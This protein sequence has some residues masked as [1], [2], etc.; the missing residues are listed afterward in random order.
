MDIKDRIDRRRVTQQDD[1]LVVD[2]DVPDD[3]AV[4]GPRGTGKTAVTEALLTQLDRH[5][6]GGGTAIRTTTRSDDH[7]EIRFVTVDC[8][9]AT[10]A[11]KFYRSFLNALTAEQVPARGIG[12][13]ALRSRLQ[14]TLADANARAIVAVDHLDDQGTPAP[15]DVRSYLDPIEDSVAVL[16]I[17]RAAPDWTTETIS[18]D[19]YTERSLLAIISERASRGFGSDVLDHDQARTIAAWANG[20]AHDALAALTAAAGY[21]ERADAD[22]I[23]ESHVVDAIDHVP[24]NGVHVGRIL[25]LPDNRQ[26]VLRAL[27]EVP[28]VPISELAE[29]VAGRCSLS[30]GTVERFC[31][32]LT[33]L[34]ILE[35]VPL[36]HSGVGRGPS[37]VQ[38]RYP[39]LVVER[40]L[41]AHE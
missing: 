18:V 37:T 1:H 25:A 4:V 29:D 15:D 28:A 27:P 38:P 7:A 23:D 39:P 31:Y 11:F 32:E 33:D 34:G 14:E 5:L 12:T 17:G 30:P 8:R 35:R 2:G 19:P 22:G 9:R 26:T 6:G 24:A 40:C 3:V 10:S 16:S 36:D 13:D 20:D 21:A 41:A